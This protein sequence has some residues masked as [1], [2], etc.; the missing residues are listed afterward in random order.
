M[1][2][3]EGRRERG[4]EGKRER[5]RRVK[6]CC[7]FELRGCVPVGGMGRKWSG[8]GEGRSGSGSESSSGSGSGM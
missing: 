1:R 7:Y 2:R 5:E 4:R 3:R 8:G 6:V